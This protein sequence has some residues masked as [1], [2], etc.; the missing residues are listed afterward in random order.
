MTGRAAQKVRVSKGAPVHKEEKHVHPTTPN[1]I[2][3]TITSTCGPSPMVA[4][5][6]H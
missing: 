1:T 3:I 4:A 6:K 2:N 5:T